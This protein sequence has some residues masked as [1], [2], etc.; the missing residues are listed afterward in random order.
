MACLMEF[1]AVFRQLA[2]GAEM[3]KACCCVALVLRIQMEDPYCPVA[4][5]IFLRHATSCSNLAVGLFCKQ[6]FDK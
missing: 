3:L 2:D 4:E 1:V 5:N 6:F